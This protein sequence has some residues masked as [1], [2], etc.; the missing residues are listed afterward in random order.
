MKPPTQ[1]ALWKTPQLINDQSFLEGLETFSDEEHFREFLL[2]CH[3]CGQLYYYLFY[4]ETNFSGGEDTLEVNYIP[5]ES[6]EEIEALKKARLW[7]IHSVFPRLVKDSGR[8]VWVMG[9]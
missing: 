3:E 8:A 5:V 4:E 7:E 9:R 2:K 1:C 6:D